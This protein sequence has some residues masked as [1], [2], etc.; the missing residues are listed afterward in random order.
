MLITLSKQN[1]LVCNFGLNK[2]RKLK[3]KGKQSQRD[4][5]SAWYFGLITHAYVIHDN[6]K[7]V[8]AHIA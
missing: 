7:S 3:K 4:K 6:C 1:I 2:Q 5:K 8:V